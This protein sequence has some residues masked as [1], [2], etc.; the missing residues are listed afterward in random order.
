MFNIT[1][2]YCFPSDPI[3]NSSA[4]NH[5][6][7]LFETIKILNFRP[8]Y[9]K[10]HLQRMKRSAHELNFQKELDLQ[11]TYFKTYRFCSEIKKNKGAI[12]IIFTEN[13][14]LFINYENRVYSPSDY[15]QGFKLTLGT[16]RRNSTSRLNLVKSLN[17]YDNILELKDIRNK[18]FNEAILLNEQDY[19]CEGCISNIFWEKDGTIY[20]PSE[21]CGLLPG[22]MRQI[23]IRKFAYNHQKLIIGKFKLE[24]LINANKIFI[25]NSLM[26]V[27][28]ASIN[29]N[30]R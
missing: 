29:L 9:L 26:G 14:E 3:T 12:K 18:G 2:D 6:S 21:E 24:E 20:T 7:G 25:T 13:G 11:K 17:C 15:E 4:F 27:M 10:L 22:I 8:Q 30:S 5:G 1:N 19:I 28:P 16:L 23:L